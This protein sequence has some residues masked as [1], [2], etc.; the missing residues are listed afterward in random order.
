MS[1][2]NEF[3]FRELVSC[4]DGF[5]MIS[6]DTMDDFSHKVDMIETEQYAKLKKRFIEAV[7]KESISGT[8]RHAPAQPQAQGQVQQ[9][10]IPVQQPIQQPPV[11]SQGQGQPD[12]QNNNVQNIAAQY[13]SI[14]QYLLKIDFRISD[15]KHP[16]EVSYFR[17]EKSGNRA[18]AYLNVFKRKDDGMWGMGK[19]LVAEKKEIAYEQSWGMP[20]IEIVGVVDAID[21]RIKI[22]GS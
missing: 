22:H 8:E 10:S 2:Q 6:Y 19:W 4:D 18:T 20:Y 3:A 15:K 21:A 9:P 5:L 16:H 1:K 14:E 7:R 11:Q 12:L 17:T 13:Q